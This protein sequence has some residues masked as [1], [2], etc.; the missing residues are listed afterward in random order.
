MTVLETTDT[1]QFL[2][3]CSEVEYKENDQKEAVMYG[4]KDVVDLF[5]NV[6]NRWAR[7]YIVMK[8]NDILCTITLD[9]SN[10]LHYFVTTRLVPQNTLGFV[11][12][13]KRLMEQEAQRVDVLFVH[14]A[15]WYK[16]AVK[17]NELMGFKLMAQDTEEETSVW[18]YS[19]KKGY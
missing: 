12:K 10:N 18:Y 16:E 17:F 13:L 4:Y 8:G 9:T 15:L 1:E 2:R 14:T 7:H 11:R 3:L 6:R 19:K 5:R